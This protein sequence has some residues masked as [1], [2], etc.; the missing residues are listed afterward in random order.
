LIE[1]RARKLQWCATH[2]AEL[3]AEVLVVHV[4]DALVHLGNSELAA[5]LR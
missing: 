2:A 5:L 4:I 1:R 3:D